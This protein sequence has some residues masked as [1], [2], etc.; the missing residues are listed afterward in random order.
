MEKIIVLKSDKIIYKRIKDKT[1]HQVIRFV[2]GTPII[3][4][5]NT[6]IVTGTILA[7]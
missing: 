4:Y 2:I 7:T 1:T 3:K 5:F 6:T